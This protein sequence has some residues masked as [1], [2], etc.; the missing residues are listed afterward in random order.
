MDITNET[1]NV[2]LS[3]GNV[4]FIDGAS[5]E[6]VDTKEIKTSL[7]LSAGNVVDFSKGGRVKLSNDIALDETNSSSV[8]W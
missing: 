3:L 2:I 8:I 4:S 1:D 5:F 6:L 7:E